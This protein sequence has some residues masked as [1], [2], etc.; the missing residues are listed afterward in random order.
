MNIIIY[1]SR[2]RDRYL[3]KICDGR[4]IILSPQPSSSV[5]PGLSSCSTLQSLVLDLVISLMLELV[6]AV[7]YSFNV[8]LSDGGE[9]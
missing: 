2:L 9:V 4:Q 8:R 5:C 1:F 7:D 3:V 6:F